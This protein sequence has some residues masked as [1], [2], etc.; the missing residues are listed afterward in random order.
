VKPTPASTLEARSAGPVPSSPTPAPWPAIADRRHAE[1]D[2]QVG[3]WIDVSDSVLITQRAARDACPQVERGDGGKY[4]FA[5]YDRNCGRAVGVLAVR[6]QHVPADV[7]HR[8]C[9]GEQEGGDRH[10]PLE[11]AEND[12]RTPLTRLQHPPGRE[13]TSR[14][15][16]PSRGADQNKDVMDRGYQRVLTDGDHCDG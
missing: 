16:I 6:R 7:K 8:G 9:E 12:L 4:N 14:G 13:F 10:R 15:H 3:E 5:R 2:L 11:L 1:Y